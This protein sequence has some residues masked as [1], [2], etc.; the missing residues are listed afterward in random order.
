MCEIS[1]KGEKGMWNFIN[2]RFFMAALITFGLPSM[3]YLVIL[4]G[5]QPISSAITAGIGHAVADTAKGEN[6][7]AIKGILSFFIREVVNSMNEPFSVKQQE[8]KNLN[9]DDIELIDNIK[10]DHIKIIPNVNGFNKIIGTIHN[11]SKNTIVN[12]R[13]SISAYDSMGSLQ[14]VFSE[15]I[16]DIKAIKSKKSENFSTN[17]G[18]YRPVKDTLD[19]RPLKYKVKVCNALMATPDLIFRR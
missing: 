18:N 6:K 7:K 9:S 17:F 1:I 16:S 11:N 4:L 10:I 19:S 15:G 14:N 3:L 12:I 2:S 5:S 13:I 8:Q